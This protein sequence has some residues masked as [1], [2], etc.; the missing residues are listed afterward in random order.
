MINPPKVTMFHYGLRNLN[1]KI[2]SKF[3]SCAGQSQL[4]WRLIPAG[5]FDDARNVLDS[6]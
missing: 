1:L 6:L 4:K 2:F 3:Y 5:L